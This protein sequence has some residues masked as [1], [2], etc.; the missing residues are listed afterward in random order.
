MTETEWVYVAPYISLAVWLV[1]CGGL[2][3]ALRHWLR[4]GGRRSDG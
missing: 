1:F 4:R 2:C 3:W